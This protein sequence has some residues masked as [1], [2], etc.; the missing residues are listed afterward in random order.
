MNTQTRE[1]ARQVT[2][3]DMKRLFTP[4]NIGKVRI[5]NR[6]CMGP[7]GISG[8]QGSLQDWGAAVQEY[9]LE[10]AKG[11]F[12]LITTGVLFTDTEIDYFDA[13][14]MKSPL[15]NPGVFRKGAERLVERLGAYDTKFFCQASM[16]IGRTA[17]GFRTPSPT[18]IYYAPSQMSVALTKDEIKRKIEMM[19]K[20]AQLY[21]LSG[22]HGIELH[23]IH[24]GYLLDQ[25]AMAMTNHRSDE[26]GGSLENRMRV[27]KEIV[28]GIHQTCGDDYPISVRLGLKSY[29]KAFNKASLTGEEEAGR[30][31]EESIKICKMLE[32]YGVDA[33][34]VDTGT[35]DSFYY[36]CPPAY[37]PKGHAL[38]LYAKAKEAVSIP[39]L[40]GS[41]MGD[42]W[43]CAQA[44]RDGKADAFV[45]ARSSLADPE[46]PK[47][48]ELGMPEKIRPCI[49]CNF[50]CIG[51]IEEQN[52]SPA[53]AVNPRALRESFYPPRKAMDP[54]T[55]IIVGG[56]IA[57]MEA[58][59]AA[60]VA[61]HSV[62]LYEKS[63]H[64][65]GELIAAGNRPL[66]VEVTDLNLWYIR[67][68]AELNANIILN[69]E[70]T[71]K[72]IL[73]AHPD[74]VILAVGAASIM[75]RSIPGIDRPE[76][77]SALDAMEGTHPVGNTVVVVGGGEIGCE[78]AMHFALQ[79]KAVSVI[80][81]L[82]DVMSAEFVPTQCKTMLKDLMEHYKVPVY[83]GTRLTEINDEGV[84]IQNN[85]GD[86][87]IL[88]ADTVIM[89]VGMRSNASM[90][91][92]LLGS[93]IEVYEIGSGKKP[94]NIFK[95]VHDAFELVYNM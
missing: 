63:D 17:P 74:V 10:R 69:K 49:G 64:L 85:S 88:K 48:V 7:M 95:A 33:L 47:K 46:F 30:T 4:F 5:K 36:A 57:G 20:T 14:T 62:T 28:E 34:S 2:E 44:L 65:G 35:Y 16:G 22:I 52:L 92:A 31:L 39:I 50:G 60:I 81:A 55:I 11:G 12:G 73:A 59:R 86:R 78:T 1:T 84:I 37:M 54:K 3:E 91:E 67:E 18:P 51:R 15:Y 68:L 83:T 19:V 21:Q 24:W 71:P 38:D 94:A 26:Y 89:S 6:F 23:A 32:S 76:C 70:I 87:T 90:K 43:L 8:I 13:K 45:L 29:V 61:G 56:G 72:D 77:I 42:P 40:A 75:P 41:R 53:C 58:A 80:E 27:V 82:P 66:K 79:G 25:F 9:F 93:G